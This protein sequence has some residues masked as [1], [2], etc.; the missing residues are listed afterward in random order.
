MG[1]S[2]EATYEGGVL[3]PVSPLPLKEHEKVRVTITEDA[4]W[5]ASRVRATYGMMG[6]KFDAEAIE[7][8]ALDPE[9]SIE[10]SP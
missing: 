2:V 9:L 3:R 5:R 6:G 10:E 1:L 8:I 7:R 4:E